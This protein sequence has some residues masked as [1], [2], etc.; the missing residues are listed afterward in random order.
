MTKLITKSFVLLSFLI[1]HCGPLLAEITDT[2]SLVDAINNAQP[3]ETIEIPAG[4]FELSAAIKLKSN[5]TLHGASIG[6]TII[7]GSK[8]WKPG[9]DSLPRKDD[10]E[11]YL[12][13]LNQVS[14][15]KISDMTLKGPNL[16]G[17][18]FAIRSKEI[19]LYNLHFENFLWA[20]IRAFVVSNMKVHDNEFVDA[21]GKVKHTGGA[22]F[23]HFPSDSEFW[24]N[25]IRKTEKHPN[26]FFGFKGVKATRCRFHHNTVD[27]SFSL[28]FPF[29]GDKSVEID[30]NS[31][32]GVISIP[33]YAGGPVFE[34]EKSFHIHHNWLKRSYAMEWARNGVE[35]D[36]NLFDFKTEDD[37]GNLISDFGRVPAPGYTDFHDNLIRNPGRGI[38]W[39][40]CG[41]NQFH[42]YNNHVI[43][44]TLSRKDGLFGFNKNTDFKSI[45]IRD[46]IFELNEKNPRPLMRNEESYKSI[47]ENNQLTNVSDSDSFKNPRTKSKQ[48][49]TNPLKFKCGVDDEFQV[50]GWKVTSKSTSLK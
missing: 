30:H 46:N 5:I 22:L 26:N 38:F 34:K 36:H 23:L 20:S 50:T 10:P 28:E 47:I 18:I 33:K 3:E 24:N 11:S 8:D 45:I 19:E 40:K 6:K 12:F 14:G 32:A 15:I 21:G 42:F 31:F 43:A 16:H 49:L 39:S 35:I 25:R 27:V 1:L 7:T 44:N 29:Q 9:T 4:R 13:S 41:Y 17:A 48:G 2:D 37:G